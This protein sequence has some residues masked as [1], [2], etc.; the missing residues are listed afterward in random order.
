MRKVNAA[1]T[2]PYA[3]VA[4]TFG[5]ACPNPSA[6]LCATH[7]ALTSPDYATT[8]RRII[9][10]GGCNCSRVMVAGALAG[11]VGGVASIPAE[12]IAKSTAAAPLLSAFNT[13][14]TR[15]SVTALHSIVDAANRA[16]E[17]Q[18]NTASGAKVSELYSATDARVMPPGNGGASLD[19]RTAIAAWW[20]GFIDAGMRPLALTT[21]AVTQHGDVLVETSTYRHAKGAGAYM[22]V[23]RREEGVWRLWKDIFNA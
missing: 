3:T 5:I 10:V 1:L 22:V 21:G 15:H 9:T 20:Q 6:F 7:A 18:V 12:W 14:I 23:W 13:I 16:F 11:A 19:G 17:T 2:T 4:P 8:V